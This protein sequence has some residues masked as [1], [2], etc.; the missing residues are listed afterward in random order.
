MFNALPI[1]SWLSIARANLAEQARFRADAEAVSLMDA[2]ELRDLGFSRAAAARGEIALL[3]HG[4]SNQQS[5]I[6]AAPRFPRRVS[7]RA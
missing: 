7:G 1:P 4:G 5:W 2:A 3:D 6:H